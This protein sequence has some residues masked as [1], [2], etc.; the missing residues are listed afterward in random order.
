MTCK[1]KLPAGRG[2]TRAGKV[3]KG[4]GRKGRAGKA[5]RSRV[6]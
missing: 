2:R 4:K 3:Q 6:R 1:D 5:G